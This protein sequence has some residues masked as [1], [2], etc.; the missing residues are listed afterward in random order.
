[1]GLGQLRKPV[2][3][4][5]LEELSQLGKFRKK[6]VNIDLSNQRLIE[7]I[8]FIINIQCAERLG[9]IHCFPRLEAIYVQVI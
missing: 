2:E 4:A 1:M 6:R 9:G 7:L 8:E 3:R 5:S